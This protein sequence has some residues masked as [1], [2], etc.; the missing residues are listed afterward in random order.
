[1][2]KLVNLSPEDIEYVNQVAK[3]VSDPRSEGNFSKALR[4]IIQDHKG[5][6]NEKINK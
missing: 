4:K 5:G 3:T 2:K 1:M 6:S